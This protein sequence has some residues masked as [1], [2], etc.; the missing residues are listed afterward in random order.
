MFHQDDWLNLD[1]SQPWQQHGEDL[2]TLVDLLSRQKTE[3]TGVSFV[4]APRPPKEIKT[5]DDLWKLNDTIVDL[6]TRVEDVMF[7]VSL[8]SRV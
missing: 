7:V 8:Y 4:P 3:R 6:E 1:N 5:Q 2:A